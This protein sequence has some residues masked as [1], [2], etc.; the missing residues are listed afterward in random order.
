MVKR[1]ATKY[2]EVSP[3]RARKTFVIKGDP[4]MKRFIVSLA[5]IAGLATAALVGV[6]GDSHTVAAAHSTVQPLTI[7]WDTISW[8]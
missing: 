5:F 2:Y 8:D 7:S 6:H 1:I 4:L 3:N